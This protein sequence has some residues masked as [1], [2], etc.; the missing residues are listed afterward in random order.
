MNLEQ[1]RDGWNAAATDDA[2]FNILT[3]PEYQ[4]GKWPVDEFFA[5]GDAEIEGVMD[6]LEEV[7]IKVLTSG[8]ALDFGCGL[9]RLTQALADLYDQAVGVDISPEMIAQ[10][11]KHAEDRDYDNCQFI[12]SASPDLR[13]VGVNR[14]AFIYSII[15]LQHMPQDLQ[16]GYVQEFVR[17]LQPGGLAVFQTPEGGNME[18]GHLSMF[19][20]P[21][22]TVAEWVTEAGGKILDRELSHHTGIG[23]DGWRYT[24]TR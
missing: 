20:V 13:W 2:M 5:T 10:A 21:P 3:L 9:G 15:T 11:R 12:T 14:F 22:A 16:R 19:G 6:H 4:G 1:I 17:V 23:F 18:N 7:G 8:H 24:V